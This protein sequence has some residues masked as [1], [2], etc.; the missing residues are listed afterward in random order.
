MP[1]LVMGL[2]GDLQALVVRM[3]EPSE[4][5]PVVCATEGEATELLAS[6]DVKLLLIGATPTFEGR[7]VAER[8]RRSAPDLRVLY[9]TA[10]HGHR[11]FADL[12]SE[13]L[14]PEPFTRDQ[15]TTAIAS[16]LRSDGGS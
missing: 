13:Q 10:W 16:A 2:D 7:A 3:L 4:W 14:L 12:K 1:I 9:V 11:D 5:E 8:L 15:L 6:T